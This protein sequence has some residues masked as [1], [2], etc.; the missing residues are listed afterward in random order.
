[1]AI[2]SKNLTRGTYSLKKPGTRRYN[3]WYEKWMESTGVP[4]Y[5]GNHVDDLRDLELGWWPE[6]ECN[7]AFLQ[8]DGQKTL[9]GLH[10][11]EIPP[12]GSTTPSK[13]LLDEKVYVL[14]GHGLTTIWAGDGPKK[15]FEWQ[16]HSLFFIPPNHSY[17]LSNTRG[18]QPARVI[19]SSRLEVAATIISD[20][21]VI[22]NNPQV[23]MNVLYGEDE[24]FSEAKVVGGAEVGE[25]R[26]QFVWSG[27]FFPDVT[28]W[29]KLEP[30]RTRGAGGQ[31]VVFGS[32]Q[33]GVG[34]NK[35]SMS[36]F[37]GLRY[38]K[39][40]HHGPGYII[41]IPKGEGFTVMWD[42]ETPDEKLFCPWQEGSLVVP[43]AA[44]YH[45]HFN[46]GED[47]ARY[48][49][50][51]GHLPATNMAIGRGGT[52]EYPDEDRWI[53]QKFEEELSKRELE[54]MMPD[55][56]YTNYDYEWPYGEDMSGD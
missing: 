17:Q 48:L 51:S 1:M 46:L 4:I 47:N 55:E 2:D 26:R 41:V 42:P 49:K 22:F 43:P 33:G 21:D 8:L 12:G 20:P 15:S 16:P 40:H 19:L 7:A 24:I 6:R 35:A 23:D 3:S 44:W 56:C 32:K 14:S 25:Y 53:R 38:K 37:P 29:E 45:Q 13:M 36:V 54:T 5:E 28:S 39:A 30:H 9:V 52:I 10:V 50:I 18:D 11:I 34:G 27:N 31:T